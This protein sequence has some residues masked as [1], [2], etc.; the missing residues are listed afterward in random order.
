[1]TN[2]TFE[3][4]NKVLELRVE[5]S[6]LPFIFETTLDQLNR[7]KLISVHRDFFVMIMI[8]PL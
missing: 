2:V 3:T 7:L 6:A 5:K 8:T 4:M 1:M